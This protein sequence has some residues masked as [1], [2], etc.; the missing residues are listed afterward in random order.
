ML[1]YGD[2]SVLGGR[3]QILTN[4]SNALSSYFNGTTSTVIISS[5]EDIVRVIP[6]PGKHPINR[7][8]DWLL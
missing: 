6:L 8:P 4:S 1:V 7:I 2:A 3:N 5:L